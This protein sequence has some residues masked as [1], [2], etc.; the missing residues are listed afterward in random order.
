MSL[1]L[2]CNLS[3]KQGISVDEFVS[4]MQQ[5]T[6]DVLCVVNNSKILSNPVIVNALFLS[7]DEHDKY[8]FKDNNDNIYYIYGKNN[9]YN[10]LG[11]IIE[12]DVYSVEIDSTK[13]TDSE[14]NSIIDLVSEIVEHRSIIEPIQEIQLPTNVKMVRI[15]SQDRKHITEIIVPDKPLC[16]II[17]HTLV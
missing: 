9:A 5:L 17:E 1:E 13:S 15:I 8:T 10:L 6:S 14:E 4:L 12:N 2:N 16:D 3:L 11:E 7:R